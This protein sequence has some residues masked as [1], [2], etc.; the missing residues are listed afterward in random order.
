MGLYSVTTVHTV[1][2]VLSY[3]PWYGS[4]FSDHSPHCLPGCCHIVPGT[5][6]YSLYSETMVHTVPQVLSYCPMCGFVFSDV[7]LYS[8][9]TV[10]TV[11]R[12]CHIV[13]GMGLHSWMTV[14]TVSQV[15]ST[16][17]IVPDIGLYCSF[18]IG[19]CHHM[20][21]LVCLM[22]CGTFRDFNMRNADIL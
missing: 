16:C 14:Q 19:W 21:W 11:F 13:P 9:M 15:L 22:K 1:S 10:Q 4:V 20:H 17:H 12:F 3:C 18:L 6:L 8:E 7:D 5:G 2:H